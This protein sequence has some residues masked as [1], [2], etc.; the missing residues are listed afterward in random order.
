MYHYHIF[1][2][3]TKDGRNSISPTT[4]PKNVINFKKI[5][6]R[7]LVSTNSKHRL[8]VIYGQP[9]NAKFFLGA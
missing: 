4:D 9:N 1:A 5:G 8:S 3:M 2:V 6:K 7:H